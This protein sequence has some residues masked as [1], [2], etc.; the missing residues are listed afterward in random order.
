VSSDNSDLGLKSAKSMKSPP[1]SARKRK[2]ENDEFQYEFQLADISSEIDL[3]RE[4][5][6]AQVTPLL[7]A[8]QYKHFD[9]VRYI[10][11]QM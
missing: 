1:G 7:V 2:Q 10:M 11:E 8:I 6:E 5:M 9:I 3:F 4:G